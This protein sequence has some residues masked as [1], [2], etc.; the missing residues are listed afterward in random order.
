MLTMPLIFAAPTFYAFQSMPNY[1]QA[2][3]R[4]N[5]LTYQVEFIRQ[6]GVIPVQVTAAITFGLLALAFTALTTLIASAEPLP[7][8]EH[9]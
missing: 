6:T 9:V 8:R 1:L 2:V 7:A 5:P 3:A 4:Y